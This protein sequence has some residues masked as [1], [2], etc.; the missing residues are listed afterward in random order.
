MHFECQPCLQ[1]FFL[2][3]PRDA[4]RRR[5]G[6]SATLCME[7]LLLPFYDV[8]FYIG[9]ML[10]LGL[11]V[12][13]VTANMPTPAQTSLFTFQIK[14]LSI[15]LNFIHPG[16]NRVHPHSVW[17]P[18]ICSKTKQMYLLDEYFSALQLVITHSAN[19]LPVNS[20]SAAFNL[21]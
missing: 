9:L 21:D 11:Y 12:R 6:A 13:S 3:L 10:L 1:T 17:I 18:I 16:G 19:A 20:A 15:F 2:G 5:E 7:P 8:R 4:R 14:L